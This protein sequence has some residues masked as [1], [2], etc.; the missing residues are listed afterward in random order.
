MKDI[1][2][3]AWDK[4]QKCFLSWEDILGHKY[5]EQWFIDNTD[6]EYINCLFTDESLILEQYSGLKSNN[7]TGTK[8]FEGDKIYIAGYGEYIAEFPF[9]ELYDAMMESDIGEITG[10]IHENKK[11]KRNGNNK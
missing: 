1:E 5:N 9:L 11:E 10:N 8:I 2:F 6:K 7:N 3:R 4:E